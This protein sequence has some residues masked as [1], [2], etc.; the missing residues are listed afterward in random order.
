MCGLWKSQRNRFQE[1]YLFLTQLDV[2][3]FHPIAHPNIPTIELHG[4]LRSL[5]CLSCNTPLLRAEFQTALSTLNP[6]WAAFLEEVLASSAL[7]I[8]SP[9]ERQAR[10]I[11]TN[12][13]GDVDLPGAPYSTF[14]YPACPQC[15]V[16]PPTGIDGKATQVNVDRDGA[17]LDSS[18][19]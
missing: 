11:K 10:G 1:R 14:R 9:T 7:D 8:E 16:A 3:S 17:W 2:D 15:L 4:Y 12:P 19:A 13:D 18:T 5:T 6:A